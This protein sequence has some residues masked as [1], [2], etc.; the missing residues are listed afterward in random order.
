MRLLKHKIPDMLNLPKTEV[1]MQSIY[2]SPVH[3][4]WPGSFLLSNP[5]SQPLHFLVTCH[6]CVLNIAKT[7]DVCST[8]P[9]LCH[10]RWLCQVPVTWSHLF[11]A[12]I[13]FSLSFAPY[14]QAHSSAGPSP[15]SPV[16]MPLFLSGTPTE[17]CILYP[18][19]IYKGPTSSFSNS[20]ICL[21]C[22]K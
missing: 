13:Y 11:L 9:P 18:L 2:Q 4:R 20:T 22:Q 19:S 14:V 15:V 21:R 1:C 17:L 8:F 3:Q 10:H 6:H 7:R 16:L 5:T 12:I